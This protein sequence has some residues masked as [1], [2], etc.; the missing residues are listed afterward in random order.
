MEQSTVTPE[1]PVSFWESN[2]AII[3]GFMMAFL[4]LMMLIPAAFV[5]SLVQERATRHREVIGEVSSKWGGAQTITGPMLVIPYLKTVTNTQNQAVTVKDYIYY[6]PETLQVSSTVQPEK[7]H[8][9]LFQVTLYRSD[10]TMNGT[11]KSLDTAAL[12]IAPANILWKEASV[13][14]NIADVKGLENQVKLQ[15][16]DKPSGFT[17]RTAGDTAVSTGRAL[18]ASITYDNLAAHHF[19]IHLNIRGSEQLYFTPTGSQTTVQV[20]SGWASPA[21]DGNYLPSNAPAVT[22]NGFDARWNITQASRPYPQLNIGQYPSLLESAFG[23]RFL[24]PNDS[25][26]KTERSVKYSLLIITLTFAVFFLMEIIQKKQIHPL[27][28]ILVGFALVLFYVLL[29]SISEY[30][31]FNI[32][33]I[34]AGAATIGLIGFYVGNILKSY[35]TGMA[36]SLGLAGLYGFIFFL[37]QLEDYALLFGSIGLFVVLAL[38][39]YQ[40]RKIDWYHLKRANH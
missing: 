35:K 1:R 12:Q 27:Q 16:D 10:I 25:Y 28:Y 22:K 8:R 17:V 33:Y 18:Q 14:M 40:T 29:L 2:R 32:A 30:S 39:M 23:V 38:I 9:S 19:T 11:F 13:E 36:F 20:R 7:R 6:L 21:F 24:Q 34:I 26:G 5:S 37:I 3:K 4:I 15:W 31:G